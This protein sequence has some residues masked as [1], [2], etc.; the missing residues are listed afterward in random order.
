MRFLDPLQYLDAWKLA[1]CACHSGC[2]VPALFLAETLLFRS[3]D[4]GNAWLSHPIASHILGR[5]CDSIDE[6]DMP[7]LLPLP[8]DIALLPM[9]HLRR[10]NWQRAMEM[11]SLKMTRAFLIS[12]SFVVVVA[13][14][15]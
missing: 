2:P 1:D 3:T 12:H 9:A 15:I 6:R 13:G 7:N 8:A 14:R 11:F 4:D 10:H 5:I